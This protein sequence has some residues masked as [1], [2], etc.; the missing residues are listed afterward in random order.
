MSQ[1]PQIIYYSADLSQKLFLIDCVN[2]YLFS[3]FFFN[4]FCPAEKCGVTSHCLYRDSL[5]L[6]LN[7]LETNL[8]ILKVK[9][10]LDLLMISEAKLNVRFQ[11]G[12]FHNRFG[13]PISLDVTKTM[14]V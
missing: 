14:E 1:Y 11:P 13:T 6:T 10:N 9:D 8:T 2:I 3:I 4:R 12:Q 7:V 5:T